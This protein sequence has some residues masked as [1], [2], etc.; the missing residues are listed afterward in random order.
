VDFGNSHGR[1]TQ[2]LWQIE[3]NRLGRFF[4]SLG[5]EVRFF[6]SY[7]A[8]LKSGL[9]IGDLSLHWPSQPGVSFTA[10]GKP[11]TTDDPRVHPMFCL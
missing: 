1:L 9:K 3:Q 6:E 11:T 7:F 4:T 10:F 2:S 8:S 5:Y